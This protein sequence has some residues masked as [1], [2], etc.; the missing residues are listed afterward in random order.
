VKV[1]KQLGATSGTATGVH[2]RRFPLPTS[3]K[4][5]QHAQKQEQPA[6]K[7][8]IYPKTCK[9]FGFPA[10]KP[11]VHMDLPRWRSSYPSYDCG[12]AKAI[13]R[14]STSHKKQH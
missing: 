1:A 9:S 2:N 13:P 4:S 8:I 14:S 6:L 12:A 10:I 7:R 3:R 5:I 11:A